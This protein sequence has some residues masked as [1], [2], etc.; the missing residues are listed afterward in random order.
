MKVEGKG[1]GNT[2]GARP[3]FGFGNGMPG[4]GNLFLVS[5][6][7]SHRSGEWGFGFDFNSSPMTKEDGFI[8]GSFSKSKDNDTANGMYSSAADKKV[9][10]VKDFWE[11]K[12]AFPETGSQ[13]K[14]VSQ[15]DLVSLCYNVEISKNLHCQTL[16]LAVG[17]SKGC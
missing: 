10:S 14:L 8:S 15:F 4:P 16:S 9:D 1:W 6:G 13:H 7:T 2:E 11:F 3:T 12:D 5:N 17:G